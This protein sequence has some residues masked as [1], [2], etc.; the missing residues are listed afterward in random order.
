MPGIGD[1][2]ARIVAWV[3]ELINDSSLRLGIG[4]TIGVLLVLLV[5]LSLVARPT[6][7]WTTRDLGRFATL[8]QTM[9]LA[10]EAGAAATFS[11]GT[12][13]LARAVAAG[14]RLQT[15]AAMP[16][17]AHVARAGAR[18]GVP[19]RVT[20][21]DPV[22]ALLAADVID[23]A[24]ARTETGERRRRSSVEFLG[25]GRPAS[26]GLALTADGGAL[27]GHVAGASA[28]ESLL[29]FRGLSDGPVTARLG[30]GDVTQAPSVLLLG[31]GALV[32]AD[33]FAAP[34]DLR[35]AGHART[36][37][38]AT[39]RLI[40]MAVVVAVVAA[41]WALLGGDPAAVITAR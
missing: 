8:P 5:L 41:A 31:D 32:G 34:A 38:V 12:A 35:A 18:S 7:R 4:P 20:T 11:L 22:V 9:A 27:A 36:A 25:E 24:H 14:E 33:L 1:V 10:A 28:E 15:L 19:L 39:N 30:D 26:A 2:A 16:L 13:G 21:N 23:D 3:G 40:G 17:L 37:V 29:L 6:T